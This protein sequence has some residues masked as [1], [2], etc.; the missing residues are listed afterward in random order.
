[1]RDRLVATKSGVQG[2][3]NDGTHRPIVYTTYDNLDEPT[4]VQQYD[5]DGVTITVSGGVPQAPSA[6]L[7]R[8]QAATN[9][10][11]PGRPYQSLVYDVNPTTG[12]VTT[13]LVSNTY[14]NHR[15]EVMATSRP[16]G[17]WAKSSF[18]GAGRPIFVYATDGAGGTTWAAAG[19]V[20]SDH[21]LEQAQA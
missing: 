14:Y 2:S 1:W 3:E 18:D 19:S 16:G 13:S 21:V 5:G 6:S 12:V 8:A 20:A 10:D 4:Q 17:L 11:D 9:Y 15:G 7:L